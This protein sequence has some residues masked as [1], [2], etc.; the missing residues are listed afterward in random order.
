MKITRRAF[1]SMAAAAPFSRILGANN[2]VHIGVVGVGSTVKIG[3]R[4]KA[5]IEE[6]RKIPG[7]RVIAICDV[8]RANLDPEVELFKKRGEKVEAY[9]DVR[10]LLDNKDIDAVS[11]TTP[12]HWHALVTVWAC[13][14]GKDVFCQ[15]PASHTIFEGRK[16]VEAARKYNRIVQCPCMSREPIGL[17]EALQW[18]WQGNLGKIQYVR[19]IHYNARTSIGKVSGPQPIPNTI[20]Y[21][22]WSGPAPVLPLMRE[23]LHYD[24]HWQWPYGDGELGNWGI[25]NLDGCRQ[26]LREDHLPRHVL[27]IGGRFGYIDDGETPNSIIVFLDY[28]S[29]P[30]IF[31]IRGLPKSKEFLSGRWDKKQD[32][33]MDNYLGARR[34]AVIHCEHGYVIRN[35]AFDNSGKL[36]REFPPTGP[37]EWVNFVDVVRSRRK[38]DLAADVLQAHLS[39]SPIHMGNISYRTGKKVSAGEIRERIMGH[40]ELSRVYDK[41]RAHL[42]AN[43]VDMQNITLGPMLTMD[44]VT[45]RFTGEFGGEANRL[46]SREYR[47]P[48]VV[49]E[50]V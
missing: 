24:W 32:Q 47:K 45:E 46:V 42:D 12:N 9:T 25:H 49:P 15:K 7:A 1:S 48:F 23:Y 34:D 5:D 27:S 6:Y 16:M 36:I 13:Q 21:D 2:E 4:G 8:D 35:K 43:G 18:I 26:A 41:F 14:A 31:E 22:L 39:V 30:I 50:K 20:D 38:E 3:G 17:R 37:N 10:K 44:R 11:V 40:P 33:T 28:D 19:G 29:A